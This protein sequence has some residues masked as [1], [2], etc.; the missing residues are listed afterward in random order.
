[1]LFNLFGYFVWFMVFSDIMVLASQ[2]HPAVDPDDVN[3]SL[4]NFIGG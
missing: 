2:P 3:G 4:S 1:M